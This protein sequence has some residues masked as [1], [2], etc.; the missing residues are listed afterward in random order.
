MADLLDQSQHRKWQN[1]LWL[2]VSVD[3]D[4]GKR[5]RISCL[6]SEKHK[7]IKQPQGGLEL[8]HFRHCLNISVVNS[9][10]TYLNGE[11]PEDT[12][13]IF[14][15]A[16]LGNGASAIHGLVNSACHSLNLRLNGLHSVGGTP[17]TPPTHQGV[18]VC[19]LLRSSR[20]P[21]AQMVKQ[22]PSGNHR[23]G[24]AQGHSHRNLTG[25]GNHTFLLA[26]TQHL[27]S[28]ARELK[29]PLWTTSSTLRSSPYRLAHSAVT[30]SKSH[31]TSPF[32]PLGMH[33]P[34]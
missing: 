20:T 32:P 2:S 25:Q 13:H 8:R 19:T 22:S 27:S 21:H 31:C 30:T 29:D 12:N 34:V 28:K 33:P 10:I 18:R 7:Y 5:N 16:I 4:P 24:R 11:G 3:R 14:R 6:V 15:Q 9:A 26:M 17:H 23:S 1:I